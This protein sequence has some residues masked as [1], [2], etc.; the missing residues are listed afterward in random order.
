MMLLEHDAKELLR[1]RGVPVPS[2]MLVRRG[3]NSA[4][5]TAPVVVKA[6]VPVGGRGKAGGIALCRTEEEARAALARILAMTIKGHPVRSCG[7]EA[8]VVFAHEAYLSFIIDPVA[9]GVRIL[10]SASGGVH[11]EDESARA[12]LLSAESAVDARAMT[13]AAISLAARLPD[14]IRVAVI[15]AAP[16]LADAF[17][18]L[19]GTLLEI[20][21]LFIAADGTWT[22]GDCKLVIDDNSL[23]RNAALSELLTRHGDLYPEMVLKIEQGFDYVELDP[24][25][26]IGLVTTGAGL[27]MQLIDELTARGL[28]PFNFCDIRTGGFRGEPDRLIDVLQRIA[29]APSIRAVLINFFA[30]STDL[31]EIARLL[32]VSLDRVPQLTAPI[33]ARMIGNNYDQARAI[34][35]AAGDPID[36]EPDLE[37]AIDLTVANVRGAA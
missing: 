32:L 37:R 12:N 27:S 29:A 21:P 17:I 16:Q 10:M 26:D 15:D 11:V 7:L 25:G 5:I 3:D 30:G 14:T 20:N 6:Q 18:A 35:K 28:N 24:N 9:G 23:E 31:A 8:P 2:A 22:I 36:V 33:T 34:I 1:A 13:K 19:E 4:D